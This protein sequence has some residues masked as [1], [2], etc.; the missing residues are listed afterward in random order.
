MATH[1]GVEA[2]ARQA[3]EHGYA[4]VI[5]TDATTSNLIAPHEASMRYILPRVSRLAD[6]EAI[7]F[8]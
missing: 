8:A 7:A 4:L 3:W 2:T 6:S 1:I 5:V